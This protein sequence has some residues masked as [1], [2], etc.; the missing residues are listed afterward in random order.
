MWTSCCIYYYEKNKDDLFLDCLRPL[1][2]ELRQGPVRCL[3]LERHWRGGPHVRLHL[4]AGSEEDLG[5]ARRIVL[6]RVEAFLQAN[7]SRR[8]LSDLEVRKRHERL[9][10]FEMEEGPY[11]PLRPDNSIAFTEYRPNM[12]LLRSR[13]GVRFQQDFGRCALPLVFQIMEASRGD[14]SKRNLIAMRLLLAYAQRLGGL[15]R[16]FLYCRSYFEKFLA[17]AAPDPD[18]MRRKCRALYESRRSLLLRVVQASASPPASCTAEGSVVANWEKLCS[19]FAEKARGLLQ[20]GRQLAWSPDD[21]QRLI[22]ESGWAD[23]FQYNET[24]YMRRLYANRGLRSRFNDADYRT[25]TTLVNLLYKLLH[26]VGITAAEKIFLVYFVAKAVE[27]TYG[28]SGLDLIS[29]SPGP[30]SG[31][32]SPSREK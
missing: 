23:A 22:E 10:Q 20:S 19:R 26:T 30:V 4:E 24:E 32:T 16:G 18:S 29:R 1:A 12:A 8:V 15:E 13:A 21:A 25:H 31:K 2:D 11:Q 14:A 7:P 27:E 9:A 17:T 3:Y 6:A 5:S 28:V